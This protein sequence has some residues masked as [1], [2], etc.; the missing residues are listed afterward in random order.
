[1]KRHLVSIVK[2]AAWTYLAVL[3]LGLAYL[4]LS[5]EGRAGLYWRF[6]PKEDQTAA[7]R[8]MVSAQARLD[9][10]VEPGSIV[11]IGDSG[12]QSLNVAAIAPK[13][14]N[15]GI[16]SDTTAGVKDRLPHYKSLASTQ[17][18][19]VLIGSNDL[20]ESD[21]ASTGERYAELLSALPRGPKLILIAVLPVDETITRGTKRTNR[22]IGELNL[23][24]GRLCESR[25]SCVVVD[26][27]PKLRDEAGNLRRELHVGDG[28]H[29]NGAGYRILMGETAAALKPSQG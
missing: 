3:H 2:V 4:A 28:L 21:V 18:I 12:I 10:T 26:A 20:A 5:P 29:L 23:I 6:P 16:G 8:R 13:S 25:P 1:M 7:W 9:A 22:A 24:I 15:Y 14:I 27:G 11:F 19:V 17:A